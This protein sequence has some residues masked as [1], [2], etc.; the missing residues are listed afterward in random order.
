MIDNFIIISYFPA[1]RKCFFMILSPDTDTMSALLG[2]LTDE[3]AVDVGFVHLKSDPSVPF[4]NALSLV[5]HLSDAVVDEIDNAPTHTYFHHYRTVNA[6]IDRILLLA[7]VLLT[8]RGYKYLNVAASQSIS[9]DKAKYAGRYSHKKIAY[10]SGLGD[11]GASGLFLHRRF[12][13]RVRLGTLFTDCVFPAP[14]PMVDRLCTGCMSCVRACPSGAL[15]GNMWQPDRPENSVIDP[16]ACSEFMKRRFQHIGRG[17]VCG[18][19]MRVCPVKNGS[20]C[21]LL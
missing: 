11:I 3:G 5:F 12:G 14:A 1:V 2:L 4:E 17:S 20:I 10:L 6:Q 9:T 19:C 13:A 21:N 15:S 18:I 7:G 8:K 16:S